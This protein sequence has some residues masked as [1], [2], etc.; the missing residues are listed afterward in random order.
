MRNYSDALTKNEFA[1]VMEHFASPFYQTPTPHLH[2]KQQT[3]LILLLSTLM[4]LTLHPEECCSNC[5]YNWI[6]KEKFLQKPLTVLKQRMHFALVVVLL[7]F[8]V[9]LSNFNG[10]WQSFTNS[11]NTQKKE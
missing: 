11:F 7:F 2:F 5:F 10:Q 1:K 8:F 3:K 4:F 6:S 9:I